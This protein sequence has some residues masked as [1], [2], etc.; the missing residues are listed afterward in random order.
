MRITADLVSKYASQIKYD[1][2]KVLDD[3]SQSKMLHPLKIM[4]KNEGKT[5]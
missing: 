1:T 4:I 2:I 3:K 5:K